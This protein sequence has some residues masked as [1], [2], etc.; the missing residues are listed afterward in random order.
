[1][2]DRRGG[3]RIAVDS[4]IEVVDLVE[5]RT[6]GVLANISRSGFMLRTAEAIAAERLFQLAINLP[7]PHGGARALEVGAESHW[8]QP[9]PSGGCFWV[10]FSIFDIAPNDESAIEDLVDNWRG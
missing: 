2:P 5:A 4:R 7:L 3:D 8:C 6:L 1:M 9:G 10:G